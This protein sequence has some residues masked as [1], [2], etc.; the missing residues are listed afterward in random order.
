M[1]TVSKQRKYYLRAC[2]W[3]EQKLEEMKGSQR[4][5]VTIR[6]SAHS[7]PIHARHLS[8]FEIILTPEINAGQMP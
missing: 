8:F 7:K 4:Q 3:A 5:G 2:L 1:A 6:S